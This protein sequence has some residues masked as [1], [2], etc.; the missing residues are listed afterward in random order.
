M[1]NSEKNDP[2]WKL[3]GRARRVEVD[4]FF[5]RNVLREV[6]K[7]QAEGQDREGV[8]ETFFSFFRQPA[9]AGV[10]AA[11]AILVVV[12]VSTERGAESSLVVT[13]TPDSTSFGPTDE[14]ESIGY[15]GELMAISDPDE[16]DDA[17]LADLFILASR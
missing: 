11:V 15:L 14:I 13:P 6:R 16:L 2:V 4:P 12:F 3:L 7:L 1:K 9:L 17:A 10:A 8:F 5:S